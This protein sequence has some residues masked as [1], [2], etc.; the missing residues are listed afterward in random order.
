MPEEAHVPPA[1]Y[2]AMYRRSIEDPDGFW[3][4]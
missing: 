2:A 1:E 4:D 3:A